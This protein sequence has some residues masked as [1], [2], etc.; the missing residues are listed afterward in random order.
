MTYIIQNPMK[1]SVV[2]IL[3]VTFGVTICVSTY[4]QSWSTNGDTISSSGYVKA[5]DLTVT[6]SNVIMKGLVIDTNTDLLAITKQGKISPLSNAGLN[7]FLYPDGLNIT[8]PLLDQCPSSLPQWYQQSFIIPKYTEVSV[9]PNSLVTTECTWVGIGNAGIRG[10]PDAPLNISNNTSTVQLSVTSP[11]TL[12]D[13][14]T[15]D[16]NG[17]IYA[18]GNVGIG[19]GVTSVPLEVNTTGSAGEG[20]AFLNGSSGV[21]ITTKMQS[22]DFSHL[23]QT[24]DNGIFWSDNYN[25]GTSNIHSGLVIAPWSGSSAGIR[26]DSAGD[27]GI[28]A[29][30][31]IARID[32]EGAAG[33]MPGLIIGSGNTGI[34]TSTPN[35]QLTISVPASPG[36][37][38]FTITNATGNLFA[39]DS[40]GNMLIQ[41]NYHTYPLNV[42]GTIWCNEIKVCLSG[43]DFVFDKN[44][45]LMPIDD[46]E[47]YVELNHHLPGI[48]SAGE[49]ESSDGVALGKMN[50][51]LLQKVEELTLYIL[52]QQ[53][54]IKELEDRLDLLRKEVQK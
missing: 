51:Q 45:K 32:I 22:W 7:S 54:Q 38:P 28:G 11:G 35:A 6:G 27:M 10:Y 39:I 41:T 33:S 24:N 31:P 12:T 20:A 17:N 14:F 8:L 16:T 37:K 42:G 47:K 34:G 4:A 49:M 50:S 26:I 53:K 36:E 1:N 15:V 9:A 48:A 18:A 25:Y 46:L 5:V 3:F 19:I 2:K 30:K 40:I 52:Q 13:N 43:C 23:S 44:Y 29:T 21:F